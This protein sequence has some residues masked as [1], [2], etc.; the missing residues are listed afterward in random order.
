MSALELK[1]SERDSIVMPNHAVS[2]GILVLTQ[3]AVAAG[4]A[5]LQQ[6]TPGHMICMQMGVHNRA[7][8]ETELIHLFG[9]FKT[10]N[11]L[12]KTQIENK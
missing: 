4:K 12:A 2:H 7:Q 8:F 11:M 9:V 6:P 3:S 10:R 5:F 1:L